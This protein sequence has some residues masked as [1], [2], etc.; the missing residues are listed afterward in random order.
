[1]GGSHRGLPESQHPGAL[2]SRG[3][4]LVPG[5]GARALAA[6]RGPAPLLREGWRS[7]LAPPFNEGVTRGRGRD[8]PR[9]PLCAALSLRGGRDPWRVGP[10]GNRMR[11]SLCSEDPTQGTKPRDPAPGSPQTLPAR[12]EK[13]RLTLLPLPW[14]VCPALPV[15][16][17]HCPSRAACDPTPHF[18]EPFQ[19][20][21]FPSSPSVRVGSTH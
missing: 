2:R 4:D 14:E 5:A 18:P 1:M 17:P 19:L 8:S 9:S 11:S 6:T 13:P 3:H 7:M 20:L 15:P 16:Q 12:R 21:L 10:P